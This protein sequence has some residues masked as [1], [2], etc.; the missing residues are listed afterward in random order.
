MPRPTQDIDHLI[1]EALAEAESE[2]YEDLGEPS[3]PALLTEAFRGRHRLFVAGGAIATGVLFLLGVASAVGL[4]RAGEP[5]LAVRYGAAAGLCFGL[6]GLIKVWTWL[7]MTRQSLV[8]E[9]KRVELQVVRSA[10]A[11]EIEEP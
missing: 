3:L 4:V 5:L 11:G 1:R 10:R 6:V 8:R 7:E 9:I 2:L